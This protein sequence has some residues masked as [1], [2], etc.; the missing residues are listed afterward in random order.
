M[1]LKNKI[2]KKKVVLETEN[3]SRERELMLD[4]LFANREHVVRFWNLEDERTLTYL[5]FLQTEINKYR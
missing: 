2:F 3:Q 4:A 1:N 5:Q